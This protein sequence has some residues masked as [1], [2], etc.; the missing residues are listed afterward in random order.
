[1]FNF[2]KHRAE[3]MDVV[4]ERIIYFYHQWQPC[5]DTF[6]EAGIVDEWL[7]ELPTAELLREKTYAYREG[8][9]S[10]II[11][12]DF[13]QQINE[14]IADLFTVL[15]HANRVSVIL[16]TQ[17]L[18]SKN[19]HFRTVSLNATYISI[20]KNPRDSSQITNFAKQFSPNNTRYL[21][22]AY[23]ACTSRA[24]SYML[25]DHHQSTLEEL[26]V[27]SDILPHEAPMKTWTPNVPY[28]RSRV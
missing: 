6:R 8:R 25:F 20:F 3:L 4:P 16:L 13:M 24:Y 18:F 12:D 15:C 26:R 1:M 11:I 27:R 22:D 2:L 21:L 28:L 9:G 17:N 7:N 10:L 19:P 14:D 23:K 5:F